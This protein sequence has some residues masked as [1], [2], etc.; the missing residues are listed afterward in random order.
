M[1]DWCCGSSQNKWQ[2]SKSEFRWFVTQGWS[3]CAQ[4]CRAGLCFPC[5]QSQFSQCRDTIC[6]V[7]W[8][9]LMS[10]FLGPGNCRA[11]WGQGLDFSFQLWLSIVLVVF[12]CG[13]PQAVL[14]GH[15]IAKLCPSWP[16]L[17]RLVLPSSENKRQS[18]TPQIL[19]FPPGSASVF[20]RQWEKYFTMWFSHWQ[21]IP[22]PAISF[23][24]FLNPSAAL[25]DFFVAEWKW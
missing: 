4:V 3:V 25:K 22:C 7:G 24:L 2:L 13:D 1:T 18:K 20:P 19:P 17:L 15:S 11:K 9:G 10:W 16:T 21:L 8:S 12:L 6:W 23:H 14:S 5:E